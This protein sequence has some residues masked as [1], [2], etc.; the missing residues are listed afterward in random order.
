M[1]KKLKKYFN[2]QVAVINTF[3]HRVDD[4]ITDDDIHNLRLAIK[5]IKAVFTLVN[6]I[7]PSFKLHKMLLPFEALFDHAASIREARLQYTMLPQLPAGPVTRSYRAHVNREAVRG[8]KVLLAFC[9]DQAWEALKTTA[10]KAGKKIR[11]ASTRKANDYLKQHKRKLVKR[12]RKHP[13]G[14]NDLHD[15]RKSIKEMRYYENMLKNKSSNIFT[16]S[17]QELIG[18]WHD[19]LVL[20]NGLQRFKTRKPITSKEKQRHQRAMASLQEMMEHD[21][22]HIRN[23][24]KRM[25]KKM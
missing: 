4:R 16:D 3:L 1:S 20:L 14:E 2:H 9:N 12:F 25:L 10:K 11:Q 13:V 22:L 21:F 8:K 5:K 24:Q 23:M 19:K 7:V 17:F 18:R 15:T 6:A